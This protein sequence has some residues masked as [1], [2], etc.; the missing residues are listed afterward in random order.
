MLSTYFFLA[1]S[2]SCNHLPLLFALVLSPRTSSFSNVTNML[3]RCSSPEVQADTGWNLCSVSSILLDVSGS[4]TSVIGILAVSPLC[5][6]SVSNCRTAKR[7]KQLQ[8]HLLHRERVSPAPEALPS[9]TRMPLIHLLFVGRMEMGSEN[10]GHR[11]HVDFILSEDRTHWAI[12][13]DYAFVVRILKIVCLHISP[14]A[15][16]GLGS[17]HGCLAIQQRR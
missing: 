10:L 15:L 4:R 1:L 17:G 3:A 7:T 8:Q 6:L 9:P 13:E 16:D 11:E 2:P 12:T 14:Y 5:P